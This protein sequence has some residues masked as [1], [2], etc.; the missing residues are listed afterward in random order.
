MKKV[1]VFFILACLL[2]AGCGE[3]QKADPIYSQEETLVQGESDEETS[4][5][6][7]TGALASAQ[8]GELDTKQVTWGPGREVDELNRPTACVSLQEQYGKYDAV[9]LTDQEGIWLTF[10]EGYENGYTASILDTL[11]EEEVPAVFF[12]TLDY[13]K[14][15]PDLVRRMIDEGHTVGNHTAYHPNMTKST[16]EKAQE[17]IQVLHDYMQEEFQYT[18]T[19]FRNPEGAFSEQVLALTQSMGY[20]T[21]LWSYAYKDWDVKQQPDPQTALKNVTHGLHPGAVYLLHAVSSTNDQILKSFIEQARAEGY[22][23][24]QMQ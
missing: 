24:V 16:R 2:T 4:L 14:K 11:K 21:V 15:E 1:A 22:E 8:L 13:V 6:P 17:K 10:D 19:L 12:V 3:D 23:F 7:H 18:M 9:F 5:A 20:K